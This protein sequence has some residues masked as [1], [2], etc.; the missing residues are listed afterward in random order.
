MLDGQ[1][2]ELGSKNI[3]QAMRPSTCLSRRRP[4]CSIPTA[5]VGVAIVFVDSCLWFAL[6]CAGDSWRTSGLGGRGLNHGDGAIKF[7]TFG[8]ALLGD[9]FV[10]PVELA[11]GMVPDRRFPEVQLPGPG[12]RG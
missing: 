12:S 1:L 4:G 9:P 7:V 8:L 6:G 10:V 2:A 11:R 5:S 3:D